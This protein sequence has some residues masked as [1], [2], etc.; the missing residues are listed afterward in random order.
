[1]NIKREGTMKNKYLKQVVTIIFVFLIAVTGCRNSNHSVSFVQVEKER[2]KLINGIESY[3][4]ID[5]LKEYLARNSLRWE[6]SENES[7]SNGRPPFNIHTII[8][9][10]YSHLG[11]L[12]ELSFGFFNNRL[13]GAIFYPRDVEKYISALER[14]GIKF[15]S[16]HEAQLPPYTRIR[17]ATDF[18]G[19]KYIEWSDIRLDKEVDLWIKRYS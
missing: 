6:E 9:K 12:G 1:M 5:D 15:D 3:Q 11:F 17:I 8:I 16:N 10:N 13:D 4:S 14:E 2:T 18:Q 7:S 19:H